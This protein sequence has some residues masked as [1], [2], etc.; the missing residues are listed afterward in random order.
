[1]KIYVGFSDRKK[2]AIGSAAIKWYQGTDYS[3]TYIRFVDT[4]T[5]KD[6]VFQASF[7]WTNLISWENFQKDNDVKF[8]K[9]F[10]IGKDQSLKL[11]NWV[12]DNLHKKYGYATLLGIILC[13]KFSICGIGD[14]DTKRFICSELV[15]EI[16]DILNI[17]DLPNKDY[18]TPKQLFEI[19][20]KI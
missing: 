12:I 9:S 1:M 2:W 3:H 4:E 6:V 8:E 14:D 18:V 13:D 20:N 17:I 19:I 15:S 10:N 5:G 11:R 7:G 16:L